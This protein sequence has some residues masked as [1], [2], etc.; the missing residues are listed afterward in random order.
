MMTPSG[1]G[2]C[3]RFAESLWP[4]KCLSGILCKADTAT[5]I[6]ESLL[7]PTNCLLLLA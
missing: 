5:L 3:R 4:T 1:L 6:E 2:R 7:W